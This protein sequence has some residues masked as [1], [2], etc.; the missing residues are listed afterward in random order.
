MSRDNQDIR[1]LRENPPFVV[2]LRLPRDL[3]DLE[4]AITG[5]TLAYLEKRATNDARE[6]FANA[7]DSDQR[8]FEDMVNIVA[9][10]T[11]FF[12]EVDRLS[13]NR[14]GMALEKA[15]QI[16]VDGYMVQYMNRHSAAFSNLKL[17]NEMIDS[18]DDYADRLR[19]VYDEIKEYARRGSRGGG[20]DDRDYRRDDRDDRDY[21]RDDRDSRRDN[22][23]DR[24]N[25][26]ERNDY[27]RRRR[28]GA[29]N[30]VFGGDGANDRDTY[31]GP[32]RRR[33]AGGVPR[34]EAIREKRITIINGREFQPIGDNEWPKCRDLNNPW[35]WIL[36]ENGLQIRPAG[37]SGWKVTFDFDKPR[38]PYYN[39]QTHILFHALSL[40]GKVTEL[41]VGRNAE[42]DKYLDFELDPALR[43]VAE[44]TLKHREEKAVSLWKTV[45]EL[46]LYPDRPLAT[47]TPLGENGEEL[48]VASA[49]TEIGMTTSLSQAVKR[50]LIQMRLKNP[51]DVEKGF[52]VYHDRVVLSPTLVND[53]AKL[54][55]LVNST[56]FVELHGRLE[57]L[58][59][60]DQV[61][62]AV[63]QRIT[64]GVNRF[65]TEEMGLEG[66]SI[67]SFDEDIGD[68]LKFLKEDFGDRAVKA[69]T[70]YEGALLGTFL[71]LA[72]ENKLDAVA[73]MFDLEE[74]EKLLVWSERCSTTYLPV[75][76]DELSLPVGNGMLVTQAHHSGLYGSFCAILNRTEDFPVVYFDRYIVT[77]NDV[78]LK[79]VRGAF[80]PESILV[81]RVASLP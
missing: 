20:R 43:R 57:K 17:S 39:P 10:I 44:E 70:D 65:M 30:A 1:E 51:K 54:L 53:R 42:M 40:E 55:E 74:G 31:N 67:T 38:T 12:I 14:W 27:P 68:L 63:N 66:W 24:N 50:D 34:E 26:N 75:S 32:H 41:I 48:P 45:E 33:R 61:R 71:T 11:I 19:Q 25:R 79:L 2:R 46:K 7:M 77:A 52:E 64:Q 18:M 73:E 8:A 15:V 62:I 56:T 49:P 9:E 36:M 28:A 78:V 59:P 29:G 23:D 13:E 6:L 76:F 60:T 69:L 81:Y 35:D 3:A 4:T 72:D 47:T 58:L 5:Y 80:N 37:K 21:R 16:G 22:R